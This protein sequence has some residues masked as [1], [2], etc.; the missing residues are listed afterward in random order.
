MLFERWRLPSAASTRAGPGSRCS[1][2]HPARTTSGR[3]RRVRR[4]LRAL[5]IGSRSRSPRAVRREPAR[6]RA[7]SRDAS[8]RA[9]GLRWSAGSGS[10]RHRCSPCAAAGLVDRLVRDRIG[11]LLPA[12][13]VARRRRQIAE[14]SPVAITLESIRGVLI[15]GGGWSA[16]PGPTVLLRAAH[17]SWDSRRRGRPSRGAG[18][19]L[20]VGRASGRRRPALLESPARAAEKRPSSILRKAVRQCAESSATSATVRF[21]RSSSPGLEKLEYRGYD[22]AGITVQGE[23]GLGGDPRRRQPRATAQRRRGARRRERRRRRARG[24]RPARH[25]GHRPH[26][27]GDARPVDRAQCPPALRQRRTASHVVSTASS[28]TP[29]SSGAAPGRRR[30]LHVETDTEM[31]AHLI[32]QHCDGNDL[33][34]RFGSAYA[35]LRGHYAFVGRRGRRARNDRRGAASECPLVIGRGDGEQFVASAIRAFLALHAPWC[36]SS[37]A[38]RSSS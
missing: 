31:I 10:S 18:L 17:R 1:R 16:L 21:R 15:G 13:P 34:E 26:A 32:S 9:R 27:L 5:R 38:T 20:P 12:R 6:E 11:R 28:R 29:W 4:S 7:P 8:S 22:S 37:R 3:A 24:A 33:V 19:L 25:D 35:R 36:S 30:G 2:H 14:Q 23:E